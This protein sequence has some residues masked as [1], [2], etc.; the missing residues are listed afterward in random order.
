MRKKI[1]IYNIAVKKVEGKNKISVI[2]PNY[3]YANFIVE[4]I[5]S[6]IRQSYP[7]YELIILDDNSTD[8]SVNV[9]NKKIKELTK[10][11]KV[12]FIKNPKNSGNVFKQWSKG[13]EEASG[14]Y[15]WI[16]EADDIA[17]PDFLKELMQAFENKKVIMSYCESTRINENNEVI[18]KNSQDL[19]NIFKSKRW[20]NN[21]INSGKNEIEE[22]L[23]VT[24][25]VLNVS[26]VVFKKNKK[27]IDILHKAMVFK[28]AGDWY[29]YY[30]IL[31]LGDISFNC[32]PLN[33]FRKH[34]KSVSTVVKDDIEYKEICYMQ[35]T[36]TQ[37]YNLDLKKYKE[38]WIRRSYMDSNV[39]KNVR[40]KRIAFVI[41][42]PG[43]GSGGHRTIIQNINA[44][45]KAGYECDIYV[46]EDYLSTSEMVSN[47][48]NTYYEYCPANVYVGVV[49]RKEYDL[50]FATGWTT[51]DF[52]KN[53]ECAKKAYFIQDYE[54]WFLPMGEAHIN[55]ENSYKL[56]FS[57]ISI[58]KWLS[59]KMK[60]DFNVSSQ[61]F[62]FC[63]DT[64]V[65]K[66]NSKIKKENA[67]CFIYQPEKPRR[68][69]MI[70]LR[71]LKLIGTLNPDVKIYLYGSS[72]TP[73][74]DFEVENLNIIPIE[75]CNELYNKCKL[76]ICI[77]ASNPSR[78]PF[79]MM[80]SG[81]PVVEIHKENNLYDFPTGGIIL[82]E[83]SSEAIATAVLD[84]LK[85]E[86]KLNHMSK[87]GAEYMKNFPLEKG[88]DQFVNAVNNLIYEKDIVE[89]NINCTYD[90]DVIKSCERIDK[91]SKKLFGNANYVNSASPRRRKLR[92]VKRK[93][94]G[95]FI[96]IL[97]RC[98]RLIEKIF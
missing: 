6:I 82:A 59:Y 19:Y 60:K 3:N 67:I 42:H 51:I 53:L 91:L 49:L 25:T 10:D 74:L 98:A 57:P 70:G 36:I 45:F 37:K 24:N 97:N 48:I 2:I 63:A 47:K 13:I 88:Y 89:Q 85:D 4:R 9:I 65:Y 56:G 29:F 11:L 52:V 8:D 90:D 95:Y 96:G 41:P 83:P 32:K 58:G 34:S 33:Y 5:D 69:D 55:V 30:K 15:I 94:K 26:S 75:K 38:Q 79:E 18:A 77:S 76:G 72:A 84:L 12:K 39:S 44:L 14:D 80:A 7:I 92:R 93:L 66:R 62:D 40:K 68:C 46:E 31:E 28:V 16:A 71:A 23:S 81:L 22:Y 21:Y 61:Y 73:K 35:E 50:L 54:P 27:Y 64:N 78:I 17:H 43:L 86:N 1:D 20:N 87:T